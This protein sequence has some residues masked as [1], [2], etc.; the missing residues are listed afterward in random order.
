M[1]FEVK[2]LIF[3]L[4]TPLSEVE[5]KLDLVKEQGFHPEIRMTRTDF[6]FDMTAR[7]LQDLRE[8][9]ESYRLKTFTHGP[10][11]GLDIASLD[12]GISRYTK[13]CLLRGLDVT[14][15]L[16]GEVMVMHTGYLPYFSRGGRRHWFRN[17][18]ARMP[19]VAEAAAKKGVLIALENSW[20]DRPEIM[21][22]LAESLSGYDMRYCIDTGHVNRYSRL[23][24][25]RWW[26]VLG[27]KVEVLHLHD[28]D[29]LSDDH[30]APGEGCFDFEQ[31]AEILKGESGFPRLDLEVS[32]K[33]AGRSREYL[34]RVFTGAGLG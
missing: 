20:D 32:F 10:F 29:G 28:N 14:A 8:K 33:A 23:P 18:R 1:I 22:R 5:D 31:L 26:D 12:E 34:E 7:R 3:Y 17:W 4:S 13:D 21:L 16:G 9:I 27:K 2:Q 25:K 19:A 6:L 15:A 11:F 30:L 24:L